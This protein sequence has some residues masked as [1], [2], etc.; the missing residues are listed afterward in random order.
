MGRRTRQSLALAVHVGALTPLAVLAWMAW[1]NALGPVPIAA[2]T[3]LLGRY[4]LAMLLLSLLPTAV[5]IV[6]GCRSLIPLRRNLGL[7]AFL[8]ATLHVMAFIGLD[9]GFQLRLV[10]TVVAESRRELVGAAGFLILTLLAV[11]SIPGLMRRL[12]KTWRYLHRLVYLAVLLVVL[13]YLWNYKELRAWPVATGAMGLLLLLV[14]LP[15]VRSLLT[16]VRD[17]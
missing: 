5:G 2:V 11:T 6:T 12:G 17:R 4:A 7:Y 9:Y 16:Q 13:H 10:A 3:R 14:R 8:Y 1:R 15:P